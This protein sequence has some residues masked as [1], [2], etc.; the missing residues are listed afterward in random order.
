VDTHCFDHPHAQPDGSHAHANQEQPFANR[1]RQADWHPRADHH[2]QADWH[3][4]V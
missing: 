2:A 3:A 4:H 1:Y